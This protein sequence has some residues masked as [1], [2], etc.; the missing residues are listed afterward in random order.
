MNPILLTAIGELVREVVSAVR[1]RRRRK[2]EIERELKLRRLAEKARLKK[3]TAERI[4]TAKKKYW[5]ARRAA[6]Q[7]RKERAKQK[8]ELDD[9]PYTGKKAE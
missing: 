9:N 7:A 5:E 3:Q 2:K 1:D 6:A 8:K 4:A